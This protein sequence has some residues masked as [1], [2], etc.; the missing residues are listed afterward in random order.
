MTPYEA[1]M[2]NVWLPKVRQAVNNEWDPRHPDAVISLIEAWH[3]TSVRPTLLRPGKSKSSREPEDSGLLPSWLYHNILEQLI[4]SKLTRQV[5]D[6]NPGQDPIPINIWLHPWLPH[7]HDRM[8]GIF[9]TIRHKL[10]V[11]WKERQWLPSNPQCPGYFDSMARGIAVFKQ[12]DLEAFIIKAVRP[13]LVESLQKDFP[14]NPAAQD[15]VPLQHIL[16]WA[17]LVPTHLFVHLFETEFFPKWHSVLWAWLSSP[18]ASEEEIALWY[19][20]WKT[21]VF[22][23]DFVKQPGIAT[24]FRAGLDMMNRSIAMGGARGPMPPPPPPIATT[25]QEGPIVC[26]RKEWARVLVPSR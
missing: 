11:S 14:V 21:R 15:I 26:S 20:T 1:M 23:P 9:T 12:S 18:G 13:K 6:W 25:C 7:L 2:Y 19:Q 17:P 24:Q 8:E 22:Q 4:L 16:A 3:V 5:A 10:N